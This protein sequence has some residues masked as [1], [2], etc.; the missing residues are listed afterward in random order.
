MHAYMRRAVKTWNVTRDRLSHYAILD[1]SMHSKLA[2]LLLVKNTR[3]VDKFAS[4]A[5]NIA[6][7][8]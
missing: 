2:K 4:S 1:R 3:Y 5:S 6:G 8:H 7:V